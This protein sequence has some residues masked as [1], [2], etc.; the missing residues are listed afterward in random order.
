MKSRGFFKQFNLMIS[1]VLLGGMGLWLVRAGQDARPLKGSPAKA[2]GGP[3]LVATY[4]KLPM[5]FEANQGQSDSQVDFL[6]RGRDYTLFLAPTE[7]VLALRKSV[8]KIHPKE[9]LLQ[10]E[11]TK[12]QDRETQTEAV[13]MKLVGANPAPAVSGL[14]EL[15][16]KVNY[17]I[18]NDPTEW[19]TN[20]ATYAKVRYEEVYSGVDLV[21]YGNQRQLEYD[22]VVAPGADPNAIA[23]EFEG[24]DKLE[25]DAQGE[26]VL[27]LGEEQVRF[28]KPLIYQ[29][30]NGTRREV[31]GSYNLKDRGQVSFQV[32]SYDPTQPL[33]IDPVLVYSTYLG[34]STE[35]GSS[36]SAF[37]G[38]A[39]DSYGNAYI[40]SITYSTDFPTTAN[41]FQPSPPSPWENVYVSKLNADGSALVYST[42]LGGSSGRTGVWDLAVDVQGNAYVT[43]WTWSPDFPMANPLQPTLRGNVDAF[44]SKLNPTGS[45]LVYSTYLGGSGSEASYG[46]AVDAEGH[47]YVTGS[48]SSVD[49]P[50]QNA[51]DGTLSGGGDLFVA[52]LNPTGSAL[53]YSTYLGGSSH[54]YGL[55]IAV[56]AS[57]NMYVLGNTTST[58]FP[59]VNP[60]QATL[61]GRED[62][63]V[64][65]LNPT[66]S[67]LIYSTYLGGSGEWERVYDIAVDS[68]GNA[69]VVGETNSADFPTTLTSL[70]PTYSHEHGVGR[71]GFVSK[72]NADGSA[73]IYSTYLGGSVGYGYD[74]ALGVAVDA[75]ANAYVTGY[76]G[77]TD[78][79]VANTIQGT[80]NG[81]S[82]AFV[83]KLNAAGSALLYTTYLGGNTSE[84]DPYNVWE[85]GRSIAVDASGNAYVTGVTMSTDFP[86]T[87]NAFQPTYGGGY[88]DAFV[89]KL[90]VE[91]PP[92]QA[93]QQLIENV[94]SLNLQTGVENNL[95]AKLDAATQALN[96]A[97]LNNNVAAINSLQ[98]FINSVEAQRGVQISNADADALI[99]ATQAIIAQL[100]GT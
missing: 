56:D 100:Q 73:L 15:P 31:A 67:A 45:A 76:T 94:I 89:A 62:A 42:F 88:Y 17:F 98:A 1:L 9:A 10:H 66:G 20:V 11:P 35:E 43:G 77:S 33:I 24:A 12:P 80:L 8:E 90:G 44:V 7:A 19:R 69:I 68:A 6:A 40:S 21:Y 36:E 85:W 60:L 14:E 38:I 3:E 37:M 97:N 57:G 5:S 46:M 50:T 96:D 91:T 49:F 51:F 86:T 95:D 4:G 18:G 29:E 58:D 27:H 23:L 16:G 53:L 83:S 99:A 82:D 48:T 41:A 75:S 26:L 32:A 84:Y 79:P 39:V 54:E 78:F 72:L 63:F 70:Q 2:F 55:G 74:A 92:P 22:F 71:D 61:N 30:E 28:Q 47:A 93:I 13:R 59:T 25:V 64:S 87:P 34:G 81:I 52:K 65:K